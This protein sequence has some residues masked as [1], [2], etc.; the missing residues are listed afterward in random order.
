LTDLLCPFTLMCN[1]TDTGNLVLQRSLW[2]KSVF[3][4]ETCIP[5]WNSCLI[6]RGVRRQHTNSMPC[7]RM[8]HRV[9]EWSYIHDDMSEWNVW[10]SC[11][12]GM[13]KESHTFNSFFRAQHS[14]QTLWH[15]SKTAQAKDKEPDFCHKGVVLSMQLHTPHVGHKGCCTVLLETFG[16][17]TLQPWPCPIIL[18]FVGPFKQ[19]LTARWFHNNEEMKIALR[20]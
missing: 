8:V 4:S 14:R 2:C 5:C 12:T 16:T 1:C 7:Q 3:M 13:H 9:K 6:D 10:P 11:N 17:S 18:S 20:N 15:V 19:N